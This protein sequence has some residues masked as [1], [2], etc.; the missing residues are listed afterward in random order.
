MRRFPLLWMTQRTVDDDDY[1]LRQLLIAY[2]DDTEQ[3]IDIEAIDIEEA[4]IRWREVRL[5]HPTD[6]REALM[7]M[8]DWWEKKNRPATFDSCRPF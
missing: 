5:K 4:M 2:D 3:R 6:M 1:V 7:D 8:Y